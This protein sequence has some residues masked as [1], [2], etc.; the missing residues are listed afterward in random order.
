MKKKT[1]VTWDT[2][3]PDYLVHIA[4]SLNIVAEMLRNAK[5]IDPELEKIRKMRLAK[6]EEIIAAIETNKEITTINEEF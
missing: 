1:V 4:G 5:P 6:T 3:P 2:L